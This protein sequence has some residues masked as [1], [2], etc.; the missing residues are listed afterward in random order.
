[1][2]ITDML[3][4]VLAQENLYV[5]KQKVPTAYFDLKN[6]KLVLP[7]WENLDPVVETMLVEHEVGHAL[8]T[9]QEYIDFVRENPNMSSILN[10]VE[11]ARVERLFKEK[12][13]GSRKDFVQAYKVLRDKDFFELAGR[14]LNKMNLVDRINVF[15]KLGALTGVKFSNNEAE[16][17]NRIQ[18]VVLFK[19]VI[20][21]VTELYAHIKSEVE[22]AADDI[23]DEN[24][25]SEEGYSKYDDAEA[26]FDEDDDNDKKTEK[27]FIETPQKNVFFDDDDNKID[28]VSKPENQKVIRLLNDELASAT[29]E[30]L[31]RKLREASNINGRSANYISIDEEYNDDMVVSYETIIKKIQKMEY[32]TDW[33]DSS[34]R[35]F[36]Q[37]SASQVQHLVSQFELKKAA[38]IYALRT[39]H[40]TGVL[41]VNKISQ[42]RVKEDLFLK[43]ARVPEGK[44]HGM[45]MLLDWSGS[46][47]GGNVINDSLNQVMQLVMFCRSTGI[48]YR[49]LA[50]SSPVGHK[51]SSPVNNGEHALN[52]LEMFSDKMSLNQHNDMVKFCASRAIL[53]CYPLGNTPFA[54]ALMYMRKYLPEFKTAYRIDKLSLITFT[55]GENT[56]RLIT[57]AD[58]YDRS[59]V[60]VKD[61]VTKK[62][63]MAANNG[64]VRS[65]ETNAYYQLLKDRFDCNIISFFIASGTSLMNAAA[66]SGVVKMSTQEYALAEKQ[67][68]ANSFATFT[69]YGRTAI[70]VVKNSILHNGEFDLS[71]IDTTS[72]SSRNIAT[73]IKKVARKSIK[74]KL[75]I[76]KFTDCIS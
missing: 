24:D 23:I 48:P 38:D 31:Q 30:V 29:D 34:S 28:D 22:T 4:K 37:S 55:D 32:N 18:N 13:P 1:M 74:G 25:E 3:A 64:R 46:M 7:M 16:L 41:N 61:P 72:A 66:S 60:Y 40:K 71:S 39:I 59:A 44:N 56:T 11:D 33:L 20:S 26:S 36:K 54:P 42:Y 45:V 2:D 75:L 50:F 63:Y 10:V 27:R 57:G 43:K 47:L 21:L 51:M 52:L 73:Q 14:D 6:R 58:M 62:H 70:Y 8:F 68:R 15:F 5:E 53:R 65:S 19:D 67:Y 35:A 69:G 17:V 49:V 12:Y 76:E 9:P